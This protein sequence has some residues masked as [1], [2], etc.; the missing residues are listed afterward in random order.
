MVNQIY[1]SELKLNK[2][3]TSDTKVTFYNLHLSISN[4]IVSIKIYDKR[5]DF[6][7][8]IVNFPSLAH[9]SRRLG[10]SL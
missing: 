7:F 3:N 1:P 10:V 4:D 2:V 5:D 9:Q 6:N 8:E